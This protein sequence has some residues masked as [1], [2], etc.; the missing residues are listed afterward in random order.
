MDSALIGLMVIGAVIFIIKQLNKVTE[1]VPRFEDKNEYKKRPLSRET[2]K[3]IN[4][5]MGYSDTRDASKNDEIELVINLSI[6][7]AE[8]L[9]KAEKH[10]D[11]LCKYQWNVKDED[12]KKLQDTIDKL[13]NSIEQYKEMKTILSGSGVK[14]KLLQD[15]INTKK[16]KGKINLE[17]DS[18][19]NICMCIEII[20]DKVL[21]S[22]IRQRYKG[23]GYIIDRVFFVKIKDNKISVNID[24]YNST[25]N[26]KD[27]IEEKEYN[28]H[29]FN[30]RG[31]TYII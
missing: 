25:F 23:D 13:E 30:H 31:N 12:S 5:N 24:D 17:P 20:E 29:S 19:N 14:N 21:G 1:D 16:I 8:D 22:T 10:L 26:M 28:I 18:F 6:K 3:N 9:K 4:E 2:L 27:F 7:S 11:E 15:A